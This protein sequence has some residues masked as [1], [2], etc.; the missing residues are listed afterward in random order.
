MKAEWW[1]GA[2]LWRLDSS[3]LHLSHP[4]TSTP[5]IQ[6]L[7]PPP[8][9]HTTQ[10]RPPAISQSHSS[11]YHPPPPF[12]PAHPQ[13]INSLI[14]SATTAAPDQR[15]VT[16][17]RTRGSGKASPRCGRACAGTGGTAWW[18]RS[19]R[20]YTWRVAHLCE[21]ERIYSSPKTKHMLSI[22]YFILFTYSLTVPCWI[23][24]AF[25]SK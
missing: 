19:C 22:V 2:M 11:G 9:L 3:A 12:P 24:G 6:A 16:C 5:C 20:T 15:A 7:T 23:I 18:R 4:H 10:Q 1:D 21:R 17:S 25:Y 8:P 13:A 14:I